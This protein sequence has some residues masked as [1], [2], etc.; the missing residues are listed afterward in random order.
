MIEFAMC[1]KCGDVNVEWWGP[2]RCPFSGSC[3][4]ARLSWESRSSGSPW[5]SWAQCLASWSSQ[6][7]GLVGRQ[8]CG[9][10]MRNERQPVF[11]SFYALCLPGG[12]LSVC[13]SWLKVGWTTLHRRGR[14][15]KQLYYTCNTHNISAIEPSSVV[16]DYNT[17]HECL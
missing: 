15:L 14:C 10:R 13:L 16:N 11:L 6:W 8:P 5:S 1:W 2:I 7:L 17:R 9:L 3:H 4:G 12:C